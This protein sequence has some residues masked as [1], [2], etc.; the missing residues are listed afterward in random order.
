MKKLVKK[1]VVAV[2]AMAMAIGML[3]VSAS[4]AEFDSLSIAGSFNGWGFEEME[5]VGDK[6]YVEV[7]LTAGKVEFKCSP[8]GDWGS[9]INTT[10]ADGMGN[11]IELNADAA[12]TYYIVVDTT[13]LEAGT[14]GFWYSG[15]AVSLETE[16]PKAGDATPY[17]AIAA[18]AVLA[19]GAVVVLA[20]KKRV[21]TE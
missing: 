10:G 3:A 13:K 18:V 21:V 14:P 1:I 7:E 2:L 15:D 11:N 20:S 12:G 9:Q 16:A 6:Y 5:K 4:A 17:I 8:I 19:L